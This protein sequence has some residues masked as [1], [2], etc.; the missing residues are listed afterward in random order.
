[1]RIVHL[2]NICRTDVN[3]PGDITA[4]I[5]YSSSNLELPNATIF[6]PAYPDFKDEDLVPVEV[7]AIAPASVSH[8]LDASFATFDDGTN[9]GNCEHGHVYFGACTF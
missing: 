3:R 4:R 5:S 1:V 6:D 7:E 2:N 8:R 9:R